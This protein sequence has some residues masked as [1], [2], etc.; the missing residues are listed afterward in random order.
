MNTT[1][2]ADIRVLLVDDHAV[3]R[4]GYGRLLKSAPDIVVEGETDTGESAY[5]LVS[6]THFDVVVMDLSLP[7]MSGIEA[8]SRI[9]KRR[10]D[11]RVLV[12]SVHE[13]EIFVKRALQAGADGYLTKRA[14][15]EVL[16]DAVR[17]VAVGKRYLD[18]NLAMAGAGV[19]PL[20]CLSRR[21]FEIFRLLAEGHAVPDIANA[22]FLS[23]KTVSNHASRIRT[24]LDAGSAADLTRLAIRRGVIAA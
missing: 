21:E 4:A 6:Q 23:P 12:F 7:G 22:L 11:T 14:V 24:K 8:C 1:P 2:Q 17:E 16:V 10:P 3:V 18:P 13:E 19:D 5:Q 15:A 9:R 20:A